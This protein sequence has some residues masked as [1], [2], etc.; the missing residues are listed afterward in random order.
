[1]YISGV[2]LALRGADD[3]GADTEAEEEAG[4]VVVLVEG[5]VSSDALGLAL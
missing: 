2:G 4:A 5:D 1:M 3:V